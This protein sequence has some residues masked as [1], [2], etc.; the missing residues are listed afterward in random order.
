MENYHRSYDNLAHA[1]EAIF[2]RKPEPEIEPVEIT[3]EETEVTTEELEESTDLILERD[4]ALV[5]MIKYSGAVGLFAKKVAKVITD[6]DEAALFPTGMV[7]R[8]GV[9]MQ[10]ILLDYIAKK[11]GTN[12][13]E[14]F[15]P[16]FDR[17][18]L[19]GPGREG[20]TALRGALDPR[21]K[22]TIKDLIKALK[23][24]KEDV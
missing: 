8:D 2:N 23:T 13:K 24:F 14:K 7:T 10:Q 16:Y 11:M 5:D 9:A 1:A 6:N 21:K 22:H 19:V 12:P 3:E 20:K 4:S 18:D 17:V 15:G